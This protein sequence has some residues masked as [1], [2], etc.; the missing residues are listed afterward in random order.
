MSGS[1]RGVNAIEH[2]VEVH[3][4]MEDSLNS[5]KWEQ[6]CGLWWND[7]RGELEKM[8][9]DIRK[10]WED[11]MVKIESRSVIMERI[12]AAWF[13]NN[14]ERGKRRAQSK[15][16]CR[17]CEKLEKESER[18]RRE[19]EEEKLKWERENATLRVAFSASNKVA[20]RCRKH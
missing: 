7:R 10:E 15:M 8:K 16:R 14:K 20:Y 13:S 12:T 5:N 3:R 4:E 9:E 19:Y 18:E 6:K 2:K 17:M 11:E 1:G